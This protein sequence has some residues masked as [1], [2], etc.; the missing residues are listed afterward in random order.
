MILGRRDKMGVTVIKVTWETWNKNL[1]AWVPQTKW[2]GT[3]EELEE[4]KKTLH[5][6][7]LTSYSFQTEYVMVTFS[8]KGIVDLLEQHAGVVERNL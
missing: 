7:I 1:D 5:P 3:E 2:I 6:S 4:F 8:R